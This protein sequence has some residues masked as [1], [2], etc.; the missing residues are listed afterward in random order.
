MEINME[1]WKDI[2]GYEGKYQVSNMGNVRSLRRSI[3]LKKC[4]AK[5]KYLIVS[6]G[7][8]FASKKYVHR[9]VNNVTISDIVYKRTWK[10]V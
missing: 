8:G 5:N 3:V 2:L 7:K 9:K 10:H 6:L 4:I 1:I